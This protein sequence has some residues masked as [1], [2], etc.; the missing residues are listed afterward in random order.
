MGLILDTSVLIARERRGLP[1]EHVILS[2]SALGES[3][4][5]LSTVSVLELTHGI[6]R[7][8]SEELKDRR[9][10]YS[11]RAFDARSCFIH[12]RLRSRSLQVE[13]RASRRRAES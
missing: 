5:G 10:V 6:Y 7:A 12:S 2:A 4:L 3:E 8:R 9:R 1:I 11:Q 13:L